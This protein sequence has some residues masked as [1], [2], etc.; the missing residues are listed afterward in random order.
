MANLKS[1]TSTVVVALLAASL[2]PLLGH[3]RPTALAM[4]NVE[5]TSEEPE[6]AVES[7]FLPGGG[8]VETVVTESGLS[9][10]F[11]LD[12]ERVLTASDRDGRV[13]VDVTAYGLALDPERAA[14]FREEVL[15][16]LRVG[17][18]DISGCTGRLAS[19]AD[20][21]FKCGLIEAGAAVL[22][23]IAGHLVGG[24]I[25]G[26]VGAGAGVGLGKL[27]GWLVA[28]VCEENGEGC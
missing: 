2:V 26:F 22:G 1:R 20:E 27:C 9:V 28:K 24:P 16:H 17:V 6:R 3:A 15:S 18:A 8:A 13:E 12:G 10:N 23:G 14:E 19:K 25:G 11:Y 5:C 7:A 21:D 4:S